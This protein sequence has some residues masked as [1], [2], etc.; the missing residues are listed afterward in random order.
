MICSYPRCTGNH[1]DRQWATLCPHTKES[2]KATERRRYG[3]MTWLEHHANQL[4][5]RR[6]KA[7]QRMEERSVRGPVSGEG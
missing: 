6:L 1:N 7:V 2:K 4:R 5:S 3:E